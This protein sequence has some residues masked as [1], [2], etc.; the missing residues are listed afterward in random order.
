[1]FAT[2]ANFRTTPD[3][4]SSWST[5]PAPPRDTVLIVEDDDNVAG[6]LTCIVARDGRRVLRARLARE[7]HPWFDDQADRIALVLI[8]GTLPDFS[9]T[10]LGQQLRE[11]VPN[12]PLLL[13]SGRDLRGV[14]DVLAASGPTGFVS[15]PFLPAQVVHEVRALIGASV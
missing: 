11:R 12:L 6:L 5:A 3:P 13:V 1:M 2:P 14:R 15:K 7:A 9:G 10:V 4:I 8:D